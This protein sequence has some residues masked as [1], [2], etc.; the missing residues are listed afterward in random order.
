NCIGTF[1]ML[2]ALR[3]M[4][5]LGM[6]VEEVDACSGPAV[7]WPKSATF[8]TADI[9]G[10]DVLVHVVKNIYETAPNDESREK[11]QVPPLVEE[12]VKRGWLGDKTGQGFYKKVRGAGE[13]EILTLDV[14]TMEYQPRQKAK[15]GYLDI[16]KAIEDNGER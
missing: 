9:V 14:N 10:L 4:G 5:T 7:G 15:L 16:G 3:L 13:K 12:M 2:D 1:S 8:R 6:T 11:Y